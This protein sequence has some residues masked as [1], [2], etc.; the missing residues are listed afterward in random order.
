MVLCPHFVIY[1]DFVLMWFLLVF[2]VVFFLSEETLF[3]SEDIDSSLRSNQIN[4]IIVWKNTK[5]NDRNPENTFRKFG[6]SDSCP[7]SQCTEVGGHNGAGNYAQISINVRFLGKK[8]PFY[9]FHI[10]TTHAH[11]LHSTTTTIFINGNDNKLLLYLFLNKNV[12]VHSNDEIHSL[13]AL[14]ISN[15]VVVDVSVSPQ[16]SFLSELSYIHKTEFMLHLLSPESR[17]SHN[18][19]T[20]TFSMLFEYEIQ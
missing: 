11:I 3:C 1:I 5:K 8:K 9:Q 16:F 15:V 18:R 20:M 10:N 19:R 7:R 14:T 4:D 17:Q 2:S 13:R 6:T 12:C